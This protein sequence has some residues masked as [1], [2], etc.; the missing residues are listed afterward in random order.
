MIDTLLYQSGNHTTLLE[1]YAIGFLCRIF[2]EL[3]K[4]CSHLYTTLFIR[5]KQTA[6]GLHIGDID[7]DKASAFL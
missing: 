2:R 6:C 4:Y 7:I 5:V 3:L 1:V